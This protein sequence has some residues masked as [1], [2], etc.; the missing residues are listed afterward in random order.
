MLYSEKNIATRYE[1]VTNTHTLRG[2]NSEMFMIQ[3][4]VRRVTIQLP[5]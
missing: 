3:L 4:V 2:Q 5:I 1:I